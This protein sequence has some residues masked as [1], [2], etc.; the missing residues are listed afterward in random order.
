M[1]TYWNN[2]GKYQ[3][4]VDKINETMPDMYDTDNKHMNVFI[5]FCNIYYDVY[6]NGG[7]N[8]KDGCYDDE[9]KII[10][11]FI[12]FENFSW[13]MCCSNEE[14]LEEK[15]NEIF[16]KLMNEDLSFENHGFWNEWKERK[17]SMNKQEGE[18]WSFITCGTIENT[19]KEFENRKNYGFEVV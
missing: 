4:W 2:N 13:S 12:G 6:N 1:G 16:E 18:N 17:I 10:E 15:A 8:I 3:E 19:K 14:Y 7:G 5:A 11:D 9:V